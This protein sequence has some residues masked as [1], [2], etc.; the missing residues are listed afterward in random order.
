M[1]VASVDLDLAR[2]SLDEGK[3]AQAAASA[4]MAAQGFGNAKAMSDE[5]E[6]NLVLAETLLAEGKVA[7]SRKNLERVLSV[8]RQ[9]HN[10]KLELSAALAEARV[11]AASGKAA[12]VSESLTSLDRI[13]AEATAGKFA[14]VAMEARLALGETQLNFGDQGVGR[15]LLQSLEKESAGEG[16]AIVARKAAAALKA[17][18]TRAS[19]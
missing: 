3:E 6:A 7:E 4:R 11:R 19:T 10:R 15:A 5:A 17:A 9:T 16:F 18:A 8:A 1:A 2:L 14:R 13:I 12:D